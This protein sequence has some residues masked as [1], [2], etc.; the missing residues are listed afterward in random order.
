[1]ASAAADSLP[2]E[3]SLHVSR[4]TGAAC[5]LA[6]IL[7]VTLE[8]SAQGGGE[9]IALKLRDGSQA[10]LER[11][12]LVA[13]GADLTELHRVLAEFDLRPGALSPTFVRS[14][15][16][17]RAE[18]ALAERRGGRRLG[19]LA[20]F[21]NLEVAPGTDVAAFV[22][23][24]RA[25]PEVESADPWPK[26]APPPFDLDPPTPDYSAL[27]TFK[28]AA[29]VG[30]G[31]A[32][33]VGITGADGYGTRFV[34]V[35]YE[36]RLDHEDLELAASTVVPVGTAVN[37]FPDD[38]SHGNAV[39]GLLS[40]RANG[41]GVT[42]LVPASQVR[43]A[44]AQTAEHGWDVGRAI[45]QA[46]VAFGP[47]VGPGDLIL[48]E[49][50]MYVCGF[51]GSGGGQTGAG[52]VEGYPAWRAAIATATALGVIVVEAAGNGGVDLDAPSCNGV[53]D[54]GLGDTGAIVVGAGSAS[55]RAP[56]AYASYGSRVDV[57]GVAE[58]IVTLGGGSLF[59][60]GDP[61]QKYQSN[62]GGSSSAAAI[63]AGVALAV[64][65]L[66]RAGGHAP[67][68]PFALR[69]LLVQT[70]TPQAPDP[71]QIGP[72]PDL[73]Q[74]YAIGV[75]ALLIRT[76]PYWA[77]LALCGLLLAAVAIRMRAR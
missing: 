72:L 51:D 58:G 55:S 35:E 24:L 66:R 40:A 48:I 31:A 45:E 54:R 77:A 42:G 41:Y 5:V 53:F 4:G 27:Q 37:P 8:A 56:L 2:D 68:D 32:G 9:R 76:L 69:D 70:G 50:Q 3:R 28:A 25:L 67:L 38:G 39:L 22:A 6:L 19:E 29:P 62:F 73:G 14:P 10:S 71:R 43:V 30:I 33:F 20:L 49:Q 63:V 34:D 59:G 18:H 65:G 12:Q 57:Q 7:A 11:G 74:A 47:T 46:I 61:L 75:P 64:Q 17:L 15:A 44:A 60:G 16:A 36:W 1:M 52:P 13:R 23:A 26:P 21:F